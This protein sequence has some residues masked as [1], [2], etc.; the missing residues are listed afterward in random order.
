MTGDALP[1]PSQRARELHQ[2]M[3][4][5][6]REQVLPAEAA[7]LAHRKAGGPDCHIVPPVVE[8]LKKR[9]R[10][11]GLWN[12][13][14]PAESGLTQLEYAYIAE[15]SG[16]SLNLAPEA[17]NSQAPDSGN[18]ELLH[19]LGTHKQ[20]HDWLQPLLAGEIRSDRKSVV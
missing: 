15:L 18:M 17:I 11:E 4:R 19:L 13:F 10:A 14:L 5:F 20:K 3:E 1:A 8:E 12:L 7:Y 6:M 16:W 2:K 9:A